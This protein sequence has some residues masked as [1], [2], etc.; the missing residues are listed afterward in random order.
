MATGQI[1]RPSMQTGK[2]KRA[3]EW[4]KLQPLVKSLYMDQGKPLKEIMEIM[5]RQHSFVAS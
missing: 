1:Q 5:Q 4:T 2:G 3:A